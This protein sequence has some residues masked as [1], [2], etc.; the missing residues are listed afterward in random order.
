MSAFS[1][2]CLRARRLGAGRLIFT[3]D[4][5]E[6]ERANGVCGSWTCIGGDPKGEHDAL[7]VAHGVTGEQALRNLVD[8]LER[9]AR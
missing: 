6:T 3:A 5:F 9:R 4:I 1:D 2:L 7:A 8:E